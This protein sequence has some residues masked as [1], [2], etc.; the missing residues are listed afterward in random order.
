MSDFKWLPNVDQVYS[1]DSGGTQNVLSQSDFSKYQGKSF[2]MINGTLK[3]TPEV[4]GSVPQWIWG[5]YNAESAEMLSK[6]N[7]RDGLFTVDGTSTTD[8]NFG[9]SEFPISSNGC[10]I[11][12]DIKDNAYFKI[13]NVNSLRVN[14]PEG[15]GVYFNLDGSGVFDADTVNCYWAGNLNLKLFSMFAVFAKNNISATN[16]S[17]VLGCTRTGKGANFS[18]TASNKI[19]FHN[20]SLGDGYSLQC[21]N[22]SMAAIYCTSF[23]MNGDEGNNIKVGGTS[24]LE[25][26]C[27]K[28]ICNKGNGGYIELAPGSATIKIDSPNGAR[29]IDVMNETY[30]EGLFRFNTNSGRS[31]NTGVL[32]LKGLGGAFDLSKAIN[33]RFF[34]LND[35]PVSQVDVFIYS[36]ANDICTLKLRNPLAK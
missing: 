34:Y 19:T 30:A 11:T 14:T 15:V 26:L 6:F 24:S 35:K 25:L 4:S 1:D 33:D 29:S 7:F 36:F 8:F 18:L 17:A 23:E 16:G 22:D 10:D 5:K 31:Q 28:F 20:E 13:N 21:L 3:C 2:T 9:D 27:D 32:S 12:V